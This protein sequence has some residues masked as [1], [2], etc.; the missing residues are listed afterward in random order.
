M[1]RETFGKHVTLQN[2]TFALASIQLV[3]LIWFFY[4]GLRG[5]QE[6]VAHV[7]PIALTLQILFMY[8]GDYLYKRLPPI[9]NHLLVALSL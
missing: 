2:L 3:W 6:L 4:T 1:T 9:A 8:Q 7:M 5:G